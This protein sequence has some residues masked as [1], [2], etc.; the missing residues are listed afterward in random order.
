MANKC[1]IKI[2][3]NKI[4]MQEIEWKKFRSSFYYFACVVWD[5]EI[6]SICHLIFIDWIY[7]I[8]WP[9]RACCMFIFDVLSDKNKSEISRHFMIRSTSY[10]FRHRQSLELMNQTTG[11]AGCS[12]S[13]VIFMILLCLGRISRGDLLTRLICK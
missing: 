3:L 9:F 5:G 12:M 1:F 10:P 13:S 7:L 2:S 4:I 11:L 6:V 8:C